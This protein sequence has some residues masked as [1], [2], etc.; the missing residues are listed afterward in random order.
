MSFAATEKSQ[1]RSR[2][3]DDDLLAMQLQVRQLEASRNA[4]LEEVNYLSNR[5]A[6]LEDHSASLPQVQLEREA[7]ARRVEMLLVLLGEKEEEL[8]GTV[9][10]M[11]EVKHMYRS[12]MEELIERV[13]ATDVA[14]AT[15]T[16]EGSETQTRLEVSKS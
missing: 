13:S 15:A 2:Q 8:E 3:R 6:E 12:H 7:Q 11:K 14:K 9:A 5:N 1:Q 4:L 10:D 16:A